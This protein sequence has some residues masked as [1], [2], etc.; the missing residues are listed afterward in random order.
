MKTLPNKIFSLG[1]FQRQYLSVI[2]QSCVNSLGNI[3]KSPSLHPIDWNNLI[4]C[5]S[6]LS[7]SDTFEHQEAALRIAQTCLEDLQTTEEQ[8]ISAAILLD[9]LTNRAAI[10]LALKRQYLVEGYEEKIPLPLALDISKRKITH[11]ILNGSKEIYLNRFQKQAYDQFMSADYVSVS[12][13]TSAGKSFILYQTIM[14]FIA[15]SQVPLNIGYIVPTRALISQVERDFRNTAKEYNLNNISVFSIPRLEN[16]ELKNSKI[17]VFTQ[18]RLHWFRI[19]NPNFKFDYIIV[20]EAQKISEG[21]RGILL[22]QK[23]EEITRSSPDTRIFYS[24]ALTTNPEILFED[25]DEHKI[26]KSV[27]TEFVAVNQNL[28]FVSQVPRNTK[29]WNIQLLTKENKVALGNITLENRPTSEFKKIAFISHAL[30]KSEG[31]SIIYMNKAGYAE[32]LSNILY[33]LVKEDCDNKELNELIDFSKKT[34]H[35]DYLL[36]KV[37][38]RRIAFHYGNMPVL[39]RQEIERLFDIGLIKYLICTSTLL[40]GVN[41][42]AKNIFLKNPTRGSGNPLKDGE[43]WNLAGRAGRLGREFQGN[44]VCIEPDSWTQQPSLESRKQKIEKS[45]DKV[46][47]NHDVLIKFIQDNTPRSIA[48]DKPELE[49]AVTYYYTAYIENELQALLGGKNSVLLNLLTEEFSKIR[50]NIEIPNQILLRNPGISPIAQQDLLN[51]FKQKNNEIESYIPDLPESTNAV[52]NSY[53]R[54][55]TQIS[56]LLSGDPEALAPYHAILVVNWMRGYPL[57]VLIKNSFDYFARQGRPKKLDVVIRDTM[58]DVEEFARFKFAKYSACYIDILRYFLTSN[59]KNELNDK[60]PDLHIWLEFGVSQGT[61][62]SLISLGLTRQTAITL[63]EFIANDNLTKEE[64]SQWI[65]SND[66]RTL[67]ISPILIEEISNC[68]ALDLTKTE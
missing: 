35:K 27:R 47:K 19:E 6:I 40:E 38:K 59:N 8:K 16:S 49:Y 64:C 5:A 57:S 50:E 12:A 21:S 13:P 62:V 14:Q 66:I 46:S 31:G 67:Q 30:S 51:Y 29:E 45:I 17:F 18:E 63:S 9:N 42:P 61:Q 2:S 23:I 53:I 55:I 4:S 33:D 25:L 28:L 3:E 1:S 39:V 36:N 37:L 32:K 11:T 20:D 22:Q 34:I 41:L 43:F 26:K 7:I 48:K 65:K 68:L 54:I 10:G 44:I 56:R 52:G 24:S 58:K 60:I 15:E